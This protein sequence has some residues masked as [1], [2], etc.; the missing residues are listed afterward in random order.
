MDRERLCQGKLYT[1]FK[2]LHIIDFSQM[3]TSGVEWSS[4]ICCLCHWVD[5]VEIT[6]PLSW[7]HYKS[8]G[9][10]I[11][12]RPKCSSDFGDK[13]RCFDIS[14]KKLWARTPLH[15]GWWILRQR[16][17]TNPPRSSSPLVITFQKPCNF[18]VQT[19]TAISNKW[20]GSREVSMLS[21]VNFEIIVVAFYFQYDGNYSLERRARRYGFVKKNDGERDY[22]L[23]GI[24]R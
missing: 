3:K 8:W 20:F 14:E 22:F 19:K 2:K 6:S 5:G 4:R 15:D 17:V 12:K 21:R 13:L 24:L 23:K 10:I 11:F 1:Q 7:L 9:D 16:I 18:A